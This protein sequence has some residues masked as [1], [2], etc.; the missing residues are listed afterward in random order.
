[1]KEPMPPPTRR[2][3][4]RVRYRE[5]DRNGILKLSSWFDFLQEAAANHAT[6]LGVGLDALSER[7]LLWVLSRLHLAIRRYPAI[8]ETVTV[9]TWPNGFRRLF[10]HRQFRL[11]GEDGG[12]VAAASSAW[13]L[14]SAEKLHPVRLEQLP[15]ALPPNAEK[16]DYFPLE[17]KLPEPEVPVRFE[18]RVR[19]TM[20]DVNGHLNNAEYA[21]LVQD[22]ATGADGNSPRFREVELHFLSAVRAPE[23]LTVGGILSGKTFLCCGRNEAGQLSFNAAAELQ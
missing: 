3:S 18:V 13:L 10:A 2:E 1:M 14:L 23:Y 8:G 7:G 11:T 16:P 15:A 19:P 4:F 6:R 12:E 20:E 21:G 9:E 17:N 5:T 22:C